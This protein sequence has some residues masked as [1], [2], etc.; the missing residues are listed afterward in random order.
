MCSSDLWMHL[1]DK[2]TPVE[3]TMRALDD[4][5]RAGKVRYIGFSDT[6]AWKCAQA[7][8]VAQFLGWTPLIALQIEYSLFERTVEGELMPMAREL[9]LGC[10]PWSP[11]RGGALSGKYRRENAA[12]AKPPRGER[13]TNYLTESTFRIVDEL[14][15]IGAERG[16]SPATV[17]IAWVMARPGV[18]S[19]IIGARTAEQLAQ[20]L[21][22]ADVA[23]LPADI[24]ALDAVS[25]PALQFPMPFIKNIANSVMHGGA[26]V[27]G[28]P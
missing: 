2:F 10:T 15:R 26:T 6:P 23:L 9:G 1:W 17:A 12:T 5:V 4:L 28:E 3:E 22:A 13:V 11:L 20:N 7:Q 14:I 25:E 24:S 19:P 16:V 21:A 8:L 27:N 18:S